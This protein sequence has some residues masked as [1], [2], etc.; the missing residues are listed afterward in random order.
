MPAEQFE[1][2]G[3][4]PVLNEPGRH[5]AHVP[6]LLAPVAFEKVPAGHCAQEPEPLVG[7]NVPAAQLVH[8][9]APPVL[10]SPARHCLQ[11]SCP[12][13]LAK[14]PTGHNA[15]EAAPAPLENLPKGHVRQ[16]SI[17]TEPLKGLYDPAAQGMQEAEE[18]LPVAAL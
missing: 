16:D 12:G 2:S 3:A 7:L 4:P 10:Y 6:L 8:V 18:L 15:Q 9:D 14:V 1:H 13:T 17:L 5:R 11:A